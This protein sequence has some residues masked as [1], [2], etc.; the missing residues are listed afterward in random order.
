M[1]LLLHCCCAPCAVAPVESL[2]AEGIEPTL[3]WHNPNVHPSAEYELRRDMLFAYTA[4]AGLSLYV[5]DERGPLPFPRDAG[6]EAEPAKRCEVCYRARLERAA[7]RAVELGL[8]A[9]CTTLLV[10]P[11]QRHDLIRGVG[12]EIAERAGLEFLYRD[13]RPLFREGQGK[14]RAMG[15]H[16]Q[17]YC[18]CAFSE[19]GRR[20]GKSR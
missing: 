19:A 2:R 13:F 10:S 20:A 16:M 8:G 7:A 14:A 18:G 17:K 6:G 11:Y 4:L 3:F 1:N 15:M 9:F 5:S 12:G